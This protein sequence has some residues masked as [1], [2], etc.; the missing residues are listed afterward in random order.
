MR[1]INAYYIDRTRCRVT[2]KK[3]AAHTVY[4]GR[5]IIENHVICDWLSQGSWELITKIAPIGAKL[6]ALKPVRYQI[7]IR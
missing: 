3:I 6:I 4:L 1:G 2:C 5:Y 7:S